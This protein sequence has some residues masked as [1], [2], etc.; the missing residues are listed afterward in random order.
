MKNSKFIRLILGIVTLFGFFVFQGSS[1]HHEGSCF[2]CGSGY[3]TLIVT[4]VKDTDTS[5]A[6]V[7][8]TVNPGNY[9]TTLK[10]G[11]NV[12]FSLNPGKYT[13]IAVSLAYGGAA[14]KL[15][16]KTIELDETTTKTVVINY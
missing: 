12:S 10:A 1:D 14:Q 16:T 9:S 7:K 5:F 6:I 15:M 2:D 3:A 4:R 11:G 8:V 13:I